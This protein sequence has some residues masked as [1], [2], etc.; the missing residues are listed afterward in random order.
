LAA[1]IVEEDEMEDCE[2]SGN[3]LSASAI[4]EFLNAPDEELSSKMTTELK[5]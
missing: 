3:L 5:E 1:E 4:A 2:E